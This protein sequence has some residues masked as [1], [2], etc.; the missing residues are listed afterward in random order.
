M[1]KIE[2]SVQIRSGHGFVH[3]SDEAA[4]LLRRNCTSGLQAWPF[5]GL[6]HEP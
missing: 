1:N 5:G 4:G 6:N 3:G 2:T